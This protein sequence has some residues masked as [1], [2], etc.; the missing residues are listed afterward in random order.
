MDIYIQNNKGEKFR[1]LLYTEQ[2]EVVDQV[3]D[4]FG[5]MPNPKYINKEDFDIEPTDLMTIDLMDVLCEQ[6]IGILEC[7]RI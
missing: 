2:Q 3:L 6:K 4:Q 7:K 1:I 5:L